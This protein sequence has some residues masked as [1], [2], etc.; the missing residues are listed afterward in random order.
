MYCTHF[1]LPWCNSSSNK[2]RI[3]YHSINKWFTCPQASWRNKVK[4]HVKLNRLCITIYRKCIKSQSW[5]NTTFVHSLPFASM[6]TVNPAIYNMLQ[7]MYRSGSTCFSLHCGILSTFLLNDQLRII[8][9]TAHHVVYSFI[10]T[11]NTDLSHPDGRPF[12]RKDIKLWIGVDGWTYISQC[13]CLHI[14]NYATNCNVLTYI[15]HM[16]MS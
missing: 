12:C 3:L 8:L 14:T 7:K 6:D 16:W 5:S 1:T 4:V 2:N 9:V 10:S 11:A 15:Q 13:P